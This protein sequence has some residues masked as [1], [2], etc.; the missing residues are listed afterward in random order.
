VT[1]AARPLVGLL[2]SGDVPANLRRMLLE[3]AHRVQLAGVCMTPEEHAADAFVVWGAYSGAL[4]D[5]PTAMW[6][7]SPA[8]LTSPLAEH[9]TVLVS[10]RLDVVRAAGANGVLFGTAPVEDAVPVS[11]WV[12][13]RVRKARGLPELLLVRISSLERLRY[14]DVPV[15]GAVG[16]VPVAELSEGAVPSALAAASAVIATEPAILSSAL[17]WGAPTVTDRPTALMAGARDGIETVVAP[18]RADQ[19]AAARELAIDGNRAAAIGWAG[20]LLAERHDPAVGARDVLRRLIGPRD[21]D[22]RTTL[23]GV[24]DELGTPPR[25]SIRMRVAMMTTALPDRGV[26]G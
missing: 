19:L 17:A 21:T 5:R 15:A 22:A 6:V 26:L 4:P 24:L 18:G 11:P 3:W 25:A 13:S 7:E 23:H 2:G 16:R 9:A 10:D 1:T 20:R 8:E 12:R 14:I